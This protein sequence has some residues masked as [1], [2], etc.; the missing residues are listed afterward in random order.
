MKTYTL[1]RLVHHTIKSLHQIG[2]DS[3]DLDGRLLVQWVTESMP[4]EFIS[5]PEK[6]VSL[7]QRDRL[8]TAL[9]RRV[10]G[11]PVHRIIGKRAFYGLD[12]ILSADTLEPRP[13]TEILVDLALPFLQSCAVINSRVSCLDMGTGSGVIAIAL[14]SNLPQLHAMA[15]DI[16]K[17]AIETTKRNARCADVA[18][19]LTVCESNWFESV[20]GQFDLIVSNPPYIA[21]D[22]IANLDISVRNFDPL[23]A[24]D[25]GRDGLDF[26]RELA[27]KGKLYLY[28]SGKIAV[29]VGIGQKQDVEKIFSQHNY[30]L[31][32]TKPDLKGIDRAL[33]FIRDEVDPRKGE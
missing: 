21:H 6:P 15:V 12:F 13:D 30:R 14:L 7:Q 4:L 33:M 2:I 10:S 26:Y 9:Q 19:R 5:H 16:T 29:E 18:N 24:L 17:D 3:A 27:A 22:D 20:T 25:G 1:G 8:S 32:K 23:R 28:P 11:E 31:E